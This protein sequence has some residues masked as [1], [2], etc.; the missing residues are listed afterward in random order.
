MAMPTLA[1]LETDIATTRSALTACMT[2]MQDVTRPGLSYRRVQFDQLTKYLKELL[3]MHRKM[4]GGMLIALDSSGEGP[5][6]RV[7]DD[8]FLDPNSP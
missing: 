4:S 2:A 7:S 3:N 1:D 8:S 5:T 6:P